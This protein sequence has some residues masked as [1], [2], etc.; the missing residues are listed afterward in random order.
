MRYARVVS[1]CRGFGRPFLIVALALSACDDEPLAGGDLDGAEDAAA[2]THR[3]D[4]GAESGGDAVAPVDAGADVAE[5]GAPLEAVAS[6][7]SYALVDVDVVLD[8]SASRGAVAYEW[9]FGDGRGWTVPRPEPTA[10]VRYAAPGR[11]AA[12]LTAIAA[13]GRRR[14]SGV[15]VTVTHA[16]THTHSGSSTVA[17][18]AGRRRVVAVAPDSDE[19]S[20]HEWDA[21]RTFSVVARATTAAGPRTVTEV[22]GRLVVPCQDA[23][24]VSV[25]DADGAPLGELTLPRGS[26]PY[27]ATVAGGDVFVS[28]Q[29][30]GEIARVRVGADG[31]PSL[32]SRTFAIDDARAIATLPDGRV[33]VARFRSA[34]DDTGAEV[35]VVTPSDG[36]VEKWALAFDPR[37]STDNGIGGVPSYLGQIVVSPTGREAAIASLQANSASGA[38]KT[39]TPLDFQTTVRAIASYVALP[40]GEERPEQRRQLDNRGLASAAAYSEH[41]DFLWLAMRGSRTVERIDTLTRGLSGSVLDVGFAPQGLA[42]ADGDTLLFVD[43]YLSR[44][45]VVYDVSDFAGLPQPLARLRLQSAEPLDAVVLRGKRLFNDSLDPRLGKDQYM[46]CAHCHLDGDSDQ[47]VWDFT[48]RG[49]G[50][51]NTISLLGRAGLGDG[52][53][54]WSANFD[55]IQDF[56]NDIRNAFLGTG[57]LADAEWSS[58]TTSQTLGDPKAGRSADLDALA[59]YVASL[60]TE[61]ASPHRAADGSLTAAALRGK[62]TFESSATG[63]AVCHAGP[64][65]TDSGFASPGQPRLHDVGTLTA[66]SGGRLGGPLT[67]LDTPTLHGL[68]HSAPYLHDG[69]AATLSDV[70]VARNPDDRHGVTSSLSAA[71]IAELVEYLSSLDG[72][73]D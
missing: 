38:F 31:T 72:R 41:G 48:D 30:T 35:A 47:R 24:V 49:E 3:L 45:L 34:A 28:L 44:E 15:T 73:V 18:L 13:D 1:A 62:A 8:G 29:G 54:H 9:S 27:G 36:S 56:E 53:V 46:A 19:V 2:D 71:E 6:A 58:G 26:R 65:L 64:R 67:G 59:A 25:F 55:E 10:T 14:T 39:G 5:A 20:V 21:A 68:W 50:L 43:A 22:A 42:L 60:T 69:S 33:A 70:L 40:S 16:I 57:L 11:Y 12:V 17:V 63:C 32:V 61:R 37:E 7:P 52:P 4:V 66:A 23:D 51:R